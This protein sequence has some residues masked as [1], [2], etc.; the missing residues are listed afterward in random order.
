MPPRWM[1]PHCPVHNLRMVFE[2]VTTER[3]SGY[4]YK[5]RRAQDGCEMIAYAG[6]NGHATSSPAD[7]R[8]RSARNDAHTAFDPLW[9]GHGAP[10][11]RDQAYDWLRRRMG[12]TRAECHIGLMDYDQCQR[13]IAL[14]QE[15]L[16]LRYRPPT[17]TQEG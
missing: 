15:E 3:W 2:H 12:M 13:V 7:S 4:R 6:K 14:A 5:C 17:A 9:E 1:A 11:T 8:T 16:L 10:M